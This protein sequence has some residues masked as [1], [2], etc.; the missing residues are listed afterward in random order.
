MKA[1]P[2]W[3]GPVT[4]LFDRV[5]PCGNPKSGLAS[6]LIFAFGE[7]VRAS[8][9]IHRLV[10][11]VAKVKHAYFDWLFRDL[12]GFIINI[13]IGVCNGR[14]ET[15]STDQCARIKQGSADAVPKRKN[16]AVG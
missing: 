15:D 13:Y 4:A 10:L 11:E 14:P 12:H 7:S 9:C 3:R 5:D 8:L 16:F 2:P 1:G 6:S